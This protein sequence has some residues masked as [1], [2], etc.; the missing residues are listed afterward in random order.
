MG[1]E[2]GSVKLPLNPHLPVIKVILL[3]SL[4]EKDRDR[5]NQ[6]FL[7]LNRLLDGRKI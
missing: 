7:D 6:F 4:L 2:V 3:F 1:E 5:Y